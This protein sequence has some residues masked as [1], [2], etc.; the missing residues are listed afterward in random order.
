[1][2]FI[3]DKNILKTYF[4][5]VVSFTN[6]TMQKI[7]FPLELKRIP[8]P[9]EMITIEQQI[10][11]AH[12]LSQVLFY[13]VKGAVVELGCFT[14]NS[15]IQIRKIINY[16]DPSREFHVFDCFKWQHKL[17][18]DILEAFIRNF[19]N[20]GLNMPHIHKGLFEETLEKELPDPISFVHI[21]CGTGSN[22]NTHRDLILFC[23]KQIY[24]RL[25]TGGICLLMDYHDK[26]LTL[27]GLDLNPGVKVACDVFFKDKSEKVSV[28]YGNH[29]SHGYFRKL[30][31]AN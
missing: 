12:L 2:D 15:S 6:K 29:Y 21:D 28:L 9:S 4:S 30:H 26:D 10:N 16:Y 5:P 3:F 18:E 14:G 23:L 11:L 7:G 13:N 20:S 19:R 1:M 31:S 24:K 8:D 25:S 17:K 27:K 22:P